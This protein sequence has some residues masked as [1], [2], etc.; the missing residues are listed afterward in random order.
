METPSAILDDCHFSWKS[1]GVTV[2]AEREERARQLSSP[3]SHFHK[4]RGRRYE[5]GRRKTLCLPSPPKCLSP[6]LTAVQDRKD[7]SSL[8]ALKISSSSRGRRIA[9]NLLSR[10]QSLT[11]PELLHNSTWIKLLICLSS[12]CPLLEKCKD[13]D[14]PGK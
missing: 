13:G 6:I 8:Q 14:Q 3:G 12:S 4:E 5:R 2:A 10:C 11:A 9:K 1:R 7:V